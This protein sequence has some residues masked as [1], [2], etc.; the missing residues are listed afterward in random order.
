MRPVLLVPQN[1][2]PV[3]SWVNCLFAEPSTDSSTNYDSFLNW[4]LVRRTWFEQFNELCFVLNLLLMR[5]KPRP[6]LAAEAQQTAW[7]KMKAK[8]KS[9]YFNHP[10]QGNSAN[11][12]IVLGPRDKAAPPESEQIG[13]FPP[14]RVK[15]RHRHPLFLNFIMF[16]SFAG[17]LSLLSTNQRQCSQNWANV[18]TTCW[19]KFFGPRI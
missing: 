6:E 5:F 4:I 17:E 13:Q 19:A 1:I 10:S 15:Y 9:I 8:V 18:P 3:L 14:K 2:K 16:S 11:R 12:Y 7:S